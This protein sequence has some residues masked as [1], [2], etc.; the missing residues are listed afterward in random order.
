MRLLFLGDVMGRAGRSA[1]AE[2][3]PALRTEWGL[4]FVVVNGEN[5]SSGAGITADHAKKLLAAGADCLT[6]G[7]HAFDQKEML[8]FIETEPRIVRPLNYAKTAPG[9]GARVFTVGGRKVLVLQAL[10]QVFMKRPFDDPFSAVDQVLKAMPLGG[11]VQATILDIHCEATSE[12]MAMGHWCD[13]RASLVVGTHTHVPTGDAQILRGGTA[14]LSDAG[15]CGD[16]D[17]VIGMEKTEPLRRFI[18]Q[19]PKGRF[20]PAGGPA[21]L[22]GV[23]VE[24]DDRTGLAQRIVPVRLGG[25][26]QES[27]P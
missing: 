18:T 26:L 7:D 25:R 2:R 11:A 23:Y 14:Y 13:G 4:D 24:T 22:A 9:K 5:A 27:R 21:T 6:L 17:S 12:K 3:L 10:G 16:Y 15:M 20:E 8:Q 19:M 1:V